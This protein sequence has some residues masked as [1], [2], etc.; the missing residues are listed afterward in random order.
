[1]NRDLN[2]ENERDGWMDWAV[3]LPYVF[4]YPVKESPGIWLK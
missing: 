2:Q 4:M 3:I 1:M